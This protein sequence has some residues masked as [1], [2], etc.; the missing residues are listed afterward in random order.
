MA[1]VKASI[2]TKE[3]IVGQPDIILGAEDGAIV[4]GADRVEVS[5]PKA[6]GDEDAPAYLVALSAVAVL[7]SSDDFWLKLQV[8]LEEDDDDGETGPD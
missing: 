1:E 2:V 3:V 7:L 6:E 8:L 5:L 4:M